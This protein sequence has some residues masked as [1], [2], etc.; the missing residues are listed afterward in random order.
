MKYSPSSESKN[1]TLHHSFTVT[2]FTPSQISQMLCTLPSVRCKMLPVN[3][4]KKKLGTCWAEHSR[5]GMTL[6]TELDRTLCK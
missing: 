1:E 3:D 2:G 6:H 4:A 5:S